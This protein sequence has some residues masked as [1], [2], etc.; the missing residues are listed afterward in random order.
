M[1]SEFERDEA[2]HVISSQP[3]ATG[4]VCYCNNINLLTSLSECLGSCESRMGVVMSE[5]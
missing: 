5:E 1:I 2:T 4:K 3:S